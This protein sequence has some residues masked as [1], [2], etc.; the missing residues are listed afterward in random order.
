MTL[1]NVE[2]DDLPKEEYKNSNFDEDFNRN[3]DF[4]VVLAVCQTYR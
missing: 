1:S 3:F 4:L 2:V